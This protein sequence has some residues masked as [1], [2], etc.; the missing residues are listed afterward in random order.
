MRQSALVESS[1]VEAHSLYVRWKGQTSKET[2][3]QPTKLMPRQDRS[4]EFYDLVTR[5]LRQGS[6]VYI[7]EYVI[8]F[9]R[10]QRDWEVHVRALSSMNAP[11]DQETRPYLQIITDLR[12]PRDLNTLTVR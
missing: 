9:P 3:Y 8:Q 4:Q 6:S 11:I 7:A 12:A 10:E 1:W 2:I 5:F